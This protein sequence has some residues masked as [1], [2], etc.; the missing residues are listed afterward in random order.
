MGGNH[1]LDGDVHRRHLANA[2]D[3]STTGCVRAAEI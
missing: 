1:V 3:Q 2:L